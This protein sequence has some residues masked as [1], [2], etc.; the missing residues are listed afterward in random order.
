VLFCVGK[1][2]IWRISKVIVMVW[3]VTSVAS[4]QVGLRVYRADR[5]K[6]APSRSDFHGRMRNR[7]RVI[8]TVTVCGLTKGKVLQIA[9]VISAVILY[10]G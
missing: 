8:G 3:T 7:L 9:L 6:T 5:M 4:V 1:N 2:G 10:N